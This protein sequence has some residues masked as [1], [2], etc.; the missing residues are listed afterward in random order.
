MIKVYFFKLN[1][2]GHCDIMKSVLDNLRKSIPNVS[3]QEIEHNDKNKLSSGLQ[4]TLH[5]NNINAYPELKM[6]TLHNT[7]NTYSGPRTVESI[8]AWIHSNAKPI[9]KSKTKSNTRTGM[10]LRRR[11]HRHSRRHRSRHKSRHLR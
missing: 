9:S 1:G 10:G 5:T 6:I 11:S 7:E 3:I 4:K 2:C 8:S